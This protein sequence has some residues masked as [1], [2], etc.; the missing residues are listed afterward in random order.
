MPEKKYELT[1][2]TVKGYGH[3]LHR[4]RALRDF[5][6]VKKGDLGGFIEKEDNLSH[7]GTCWVADDAKVYGSAKIDGNVGVFDNA[8]VYGNAKIGDNAMVLDKAFVYGN[9]IVYGN[10]KVYKRADVCG[11][12]M[13]Y[14]NAEVGGD[15]KV[16]GKVS[17]GI[18]DGN[19]KKDI[20]LD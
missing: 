20:E 7:K 9:A 6:D 11:Y 1:N 8:R 5:G 19:K 15:A 16:T 18:I 2:E 13:V 17:E 10:A 4:I 3:T 12:A 14:G